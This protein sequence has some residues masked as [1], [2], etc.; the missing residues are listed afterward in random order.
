MFW[1]EFVGSLLIPVKSSEIL[2]KK[3]DHRT[4]SPIISKLRMKVGCRR[5][6]SKTKTGKM[7]IIRNQPQSTYTG[8]ASVQNHAWLALVTSLLLRYVKGVGRMKYLSYLNV[9]VLWMVPY[10]TR[11]K[12]W[13]NPYNNLIM[14]HLII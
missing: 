8:G 1:L 3:I 14:T 13:L 7:N 10:F 2:A 9:H 4:S 12:V 11:N 5:A 6:I